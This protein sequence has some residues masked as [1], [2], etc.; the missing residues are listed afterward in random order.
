MI[1]PIK[2]FFKTIWHFFPSF[3][4]WLKDIPDFRDKN[5]SDYSL[6][7]LFW[8]GVFLFLFK[9]KS[10]RNI[11]FRLNSTEFM[12]NLNHLIK[13]PNC[14]NTVPH[15]D[16]LNYL[17]KGISSKWFAGVRTEMVRT[18]IRKKCFINDRLGGKYY[19]IVID[20]TW[21]LNFKKRHCKGCLKRAINEDKYIYYHPVL[22]AKLITFNGMA[23]SIATE[24]IENEGLSSKQDCE[25]KAFYRLAKRLKADF[26]QMKICLVADAL[27]AAK[28]VFDICEK[29]HWKYI[30]TFKEGSM[31]ETYAEFESLRD[32]APE[33]KENFTTAKVI[34]DYRWVT[35][36]DYDAHSLNVLECIEINRKN[37]KV[38]KF[39][40]VT[41]LS[42]R[43]D[44]I[45]Q[46]AQGGRSR[47]KIENE[48]FN[49]QKNG[50]YGLEHAYSLNTEAMKNF[51]FLLQIAH[52][53]S[54]IMEKG[55][56]LKNSL[57]KIYG[58]IK[59]FSMAFW[60]AF[61]S[62]SLNRCE[63]DEMLNSR[64]QI[65]FNTS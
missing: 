9:F 17:F 40:W 44:N 33:N 34:Q 38:T 2:V 64:I 22:E 39:V 14:L 65:R 11:K 51:Y 29:F 7:Q 15:G 32:L 27:Y 31:P 12:K 58:S 46:I 36:I 52:I 26:P 19:L 3:S 41:N 37:N 5:K 63:I 24:F 25:L 6:S 16:T 55:N 53:I 50:G 42:I 62:K 18:L 56:L 28:Q 4:S 61:V 47:W 20:G 13:P 23:L 1:E 45:L 8:V 49:M 10:R 48:G 57:L 54:Q 30:I 21:V 43:P 35:E 59:N 60:I